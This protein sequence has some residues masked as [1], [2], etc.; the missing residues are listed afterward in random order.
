MCK[1][2]KTTLTPDPHLCSD[3]MEEAWVGHISIEPLHGLHKGPSGWRLLQ[4][5]EVHGLHLLIHRNL[6]WPQTAATR[7]GRHADMD[8]KVTRGAHT[9]DEGGKEGVSAGQWT[10]KY[11]QYRH[12]VLYHNKTKNTVCKY[13]L[14]TTLITIL[15]PKT[16]KIEDKLRKESNS[17]Q[18]YSQTT[19]CLAIIYIYQWHSNHTCL[20]RYSFCFLLVHTR[21]EASVGCLGSW[22][23]QTHQTADVWWPQRR[24]WCHVQANTSHSHT[25]SSSQGHCVCDLLCAQGIHI[26]MLCARLHWKLTK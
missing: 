5:L 24:S 12:E 14:M 25:R 1:L 16:K 4:E 15:L 19:H 22:P 20:R 8:V 3:S 23:E 10:S 21:P 2:L 9:I 6:Q 17:L 13:I 18:A 11:F 7:S 26:M